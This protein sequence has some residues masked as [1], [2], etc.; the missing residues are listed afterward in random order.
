M[1]AAFDDRVIV[2]AQ[3]ALASIAYS[4]STSRPLSKKQQR[5]KD[6]I[7]EAISVDTVMATA[8]GLLDGVRSVQTSHTTAESIAA[9]WE[10]KAREKIVG[11]GIVA[12]LLWALFYKWVLPMLLEWAQMW[13]IDQLKSNVSITTKFPATQGRTSDR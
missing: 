5:H 8:V 4:T 7:V 9:L 2:R 11:S 3:Q 1:T 6:A 13:L 10:D 12:S